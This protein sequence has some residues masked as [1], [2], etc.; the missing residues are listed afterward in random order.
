MARSRTGT[1]SLGQGTVWSLQAASCLAV[2][3]AAGRIEGPVV[4]GV[5]VQGESSIVETRDTPL[6]LSLS[7]E[8]TVSSR[9]HEKLRSL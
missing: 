9:D 2:Q 6:A 3:V 8:S 4:G 7:L 5:V 1:V